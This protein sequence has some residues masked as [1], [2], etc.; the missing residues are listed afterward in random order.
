MKLELMT[1]I[2]LFVFAG[3]AQFIDPTT[4]VI[5]ET[6]ARYQLMEGIDVAIN[7]VMK[8]GKTASIGN[9]LKELEEMQRA[10]DVKLPY[11]YDAKFTCNSRGKSKASYKLSKENQRRKTEFEAV[12]KRRIQAMVPDAAIQ[13]PSLTEEPRPRDFKSREEFI[14][15]YVLY[16]TED[17]DEETK[18]KY[19]KKLGG[20][21]QY[22][23]DVKNEA[24][25]LWKES[26]L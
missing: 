12:V 15:A 25:K 1:C 20:L 21:S 17:I 5:V 18:Q 16:K 3:V 26:Q 14:K 13:V 19:A 8:K 22:K 2:I 4:T 10:H 24:A 9:V 7:N 11:S 6:P 23:R